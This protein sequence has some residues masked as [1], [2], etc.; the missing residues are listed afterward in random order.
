MKVAFVTGSNKGI[1][2]AIVENL[3]R[4]LGPSGEWD[5]YLTGMLSRDLPNVPIVARNEELGKKTCSELEKKGLSVKFHQL[6]INNVESRKK[7]IEFLTSHYP[8]GI[9]IAINNA[10]I[11]FKSDST[12]S[13]GEQARVTL[14]T[15]F[16][17]TLSFTEEFMPYLAKDA[18]LVHFIYIYME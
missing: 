2:R 13:F 10:G 11:I 14:K 16:F 1:G 8:N 15:N 3:A 4:T 9:N 7:F 17:D 12:A 6:D 5:I 18:R